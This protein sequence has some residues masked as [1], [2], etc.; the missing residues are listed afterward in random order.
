MRVTILGSGT[1][2]PDDARRSAAHLVEAEGIRLLMD[3]GSGTVHGFT[4]ARAIEST[5]SG[6]SSEHDGPAPAES[7]EATDRSRLSSPD[8]RALTHLAITHFHTDHVGDIPALLFALKH[9]VGDARVE[10]LT[11]LGPPGIRSF[12]SALTTAF[13]EHIT[14]PGFPVDVVELERSDAWRSEDGRLTVRTHPTPHT[15]ESVA[16]RVET[17]KGVVGYTGDTGPDEGLAKFFGGVDLLI[18]ECSL[19]DPP[20]MTSHLSPLGVARLAG[21]AR[22]GTVVVTHVFPNLDPARAPALI[23][24]AGYD[25]RVVTGY[26]GLTLDVRG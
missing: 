6:G 26:D 2:V 21:T 8:W 19:P 15:A 18:A 4:R 11:V 3:C 14:D 25:G 24:E 1:L 12:W 9:G 20:G 13:G 7:A 17:G 10:P 16:F 23:R 5:G 22:P